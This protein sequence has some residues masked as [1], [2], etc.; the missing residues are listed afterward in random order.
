MLIS[1]PQEHSSHIY[2]FIEIFQDGTS[3]NQAGNEV[4][5]IGSLEEM[6]LS[7]IILSYETN[8]ISKA[9]KQRGP[10]PAFPAGQ[11]AIFDPL[12]SISDQACL[13]LDFHHWSTS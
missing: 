2:T 5:R 8:R 12:S 11:R 10:T 13:Q 7:V 3:L 9:N 6:M 4:P 1:V